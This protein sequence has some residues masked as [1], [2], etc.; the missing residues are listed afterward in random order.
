MEGVV[1]IPIEDLSQIMVHG[2]NIR[3]STMDLS[4]LTQNKVSLMTLDEKYLPTAIV[5]PFEGHARQ[6]KMM[7]AQ[8]KV[9][10]SKYLDLWVQIIKK[11]ISNQARV[12]SILGLHSAEKVASFVEKVTTDDV[13]SMEGI[14][15]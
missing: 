15:E 3:L 7:H 1:F 11:K 4:I 14:T 13:D 2:A 5:L 8:V 10:S 9:E 6:Y 12:L